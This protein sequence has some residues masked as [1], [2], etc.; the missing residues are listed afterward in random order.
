MTLFSDNDLLMIALILDKDEEE[1]V[2]KKKTVY[3]FIRH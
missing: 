2:V 1:D 3:G